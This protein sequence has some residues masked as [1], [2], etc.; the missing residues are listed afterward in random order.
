MII[1]TGALTEDAAIAC[2]DK[3]MANYVL[4]GNLTRLGPA[5]KQALAKQ[6]LEQVRKNYEKELERAYEELKQ[7]ADAINELLR[8]KDEFI[9]Q[10]GHDLKTPLSVL[11]N[12]LP[13]IAEDIDDFEIKEDCKVAIR[14]V[15]YIENLVKETLKI[16]EL[17]SPNVQFDIQDTNLLGLV[18]NVISDNRLVFKQE[19]IKIK[20]MVDEKIFVRAD[21]LRLS[22]IF[23]NL[24]SNAVKYSG[25][26]GGTITIEANN[27]KNYV[28]ISVRDTGIGMTGKQM[29]HI[30]DE[31][32]KADDSRHCLE[33][34]GLGLSICKRIVEKHGGKIWVESQGGGKGTT[35]CFTLKS[36]KKEGK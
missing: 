16:A 30:F 18:N 24:I 14:N 23:N 4:K 19:N 13:M 12:I 6:Y 22:E 3:G 29:A 10:L 7:R 17:S 36:G 26:N 32:Y 2:I 27:G 35:F 25:D 11:M 8:Q 20:T 21:E 28:I 9:G 34:C 33:S 5:V 15:K 1:V 31:F